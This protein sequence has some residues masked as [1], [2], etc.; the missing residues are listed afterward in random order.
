[1]EW[2]FFTAETDNGINC[3]LCSETISTQMSS[4]QAL[5][6]PIEINLRGK[7]TVAFRL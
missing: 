6:N 3:S 2:S 4:K 1:M 7:K 5:R